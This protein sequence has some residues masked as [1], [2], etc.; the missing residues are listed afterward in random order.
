MD[1]DL[2]DPAVQ[3]LVDAHPTLFGGEPPRV[4]SDLPAGW[5]HLVDSLCN[6]LEDELGDDAHQHFLVAQIKEKLG[7]LRFYYRF[8]CD[9]A[10]EDDKPAGGGF[11]G[12]APG[13]PTEQ[14]ARVRA[15]VDAALFESEET[16]LECGAAGA[17]RNVDGYLT[18]L[19]DAHHHAAISGQAP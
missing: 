11:D 2:V 12:S 9:E 6:A 10:D 1:D 19:C 3:R 18:T 15:L 14:R 7:T 16:C 17:L 8:A 5:Y 13:L 4:L